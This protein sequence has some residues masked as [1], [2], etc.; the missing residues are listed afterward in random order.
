MHCITNFPVFLFIKYCNAI[1]FVMVMYNHIFSHMG[2]L[3]KKNTL[4]FFKQETRQCHETR[5][6]RDALSIFS[7]VGKDFTGHY[8]PSFSAIY[9]YALLNLSAL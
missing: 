7:K 5:F 8:L 3:L 6:S 4:N 2:L 1:D 9:M